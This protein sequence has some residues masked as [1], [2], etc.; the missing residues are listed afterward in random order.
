MPEFRF[1][2]DVD[3]LR[4]V[5]SE[6]G[7]NKA[8]IRTYGCQQNVSDSEKIKGILEQAGCEISA[9][10]NSADIV[11]FNTCA[12]RQTAENRIFGHIG[13][14]KKT[15]AKRSQ[16]LIMLG[17]CM[18]QQPY[19][20]ERIRESYPYIDV[21]FNT[22]DLCLLP[23]L[24]ISGILKKER[25]FNSLSDTYSLNEGIPVSRSS[26]YRALLPVM[27]GCDNYC[28]YCVVPFV[29]G[30]ERS[31]K[32]KDV[33]REFKQIVN[34]G[35]KEIML[36]GQNVNSY[37]KNSF[38]GDDF[39]GLLAALGDEDGDFILRF[40]TS[41]PKDASSKM[42]N[43]IADYP[44]ISRTIHLPVQSGSNRILDL[45][46]RGY[47]RECYLELL[48]RAREKI[49]S[50]LFTSDIIIGFPGETDDDF[51]QT[52]DLVKSAGFYSLFIF[53]YSNRAGTKAAMLPDEIPHKLK[54]ER[55]IALTRIQ[56]SISE[57]YDRMLLGRSIRGI[58]AEKLLNGN[59][60]V[61]LDNN[62]VVE[63]SGNGSVGNYCNI[64]VTDIKKRRLYGKIF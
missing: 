25:Q 9:E 59:L 57:G 47:T 56:D 38:E 53:I 62:S 64:K 3:K 44:K 11:I 54:T 17:G 63:A 60:E 51:M 2:K 5:L 55:L 21:L 10:Q 26:G 12:I 30:R 49:D 20:V 40:M 42:F 14:L 28:S 61:R 39:P 48:E 6:R 22:N 46:N 31:R 16:K 36:L 34:N 4:I 8:H 41:H 1:E 24:M 52:V 43:V 45:M 18:V 27:Y 15:H 58:I 32:S 35:Y 23:K 7:I 29:R 37:G 19:I 50:V 33:I 13:E